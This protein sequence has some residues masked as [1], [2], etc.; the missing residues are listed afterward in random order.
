MFLRLYTGVSTWW[1]DLKGRAAEEGGATA[2]EYALM[3]ALI[4]VVIIAPPLIPNTGPSDASR[5]QSTGRLPIL[6]SPWVSDD[7]CR[8]LAFARLRRRD[9]SHAD[10]LR[11]GHACQSV[12]HGQPNLGLV[13]AVELDLVRLEPELRRDVGYQGGA[14]RPGRSRGSRAWGDHSIAA[15]PGY[16]EAALIRV[17]PR[18]QAVAA[19]EG[20]LLVHAA[21]RHGVVHPDA[22]P[23][24]QARSLRRLPHVPR[25]RRGR[26]AA[27]ARVRR[28]CRA[29]AWSSRRTARRA[30]AQDADR[31][32][33]RRAPEREPGRP[34][35]RAHRPGR[36]ARRGGA[37]RP[38][39]RGARAVRRPQPPDGLRPR[40]LHP[41]QP[42]RALH[43]GG[44]AVLCARRSRGAAP[45]RGS[46]RRT[47]TP[48]STPSASSA[49]AAS[50]SA[51]PAPS[52]RSSSTGA[53]PATSAALEK[54][55]TTCTFCGVGCQIDLN[56]DPQTKRIVKV[57]SEPGLRLER[58]QPLRQGPLRL[59]LRPP[60][61]PA[62]ASRSSAART[63]S[64]TRPT[65]T[66]RC[67]PRPTG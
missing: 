8:R 32:A 14:S 10:E 12:E 60:P 59:Q 62:D 43:A 53:P 28:A 66:R 13:V 44:H 30:P 21:A 61:R 36:G 2:V 18:R 51:R 24:R 29:R 3:V 20:E 42:L 4:A 7:R 58:G 11:V 47:A 50:P 34:A 23:R 65:G 48:G 67:R 6:P 41:L 63:A 56:V 46:C 17:H 54:T 38:P 27:G 19:P 57:T 16:D 1:N 55:K 33:A 64:C 35:E 52:T 49:A 15:L 37:V 45:R 25:R 26:A 31:D 5:R 9:R 40:R 22:L 39:R